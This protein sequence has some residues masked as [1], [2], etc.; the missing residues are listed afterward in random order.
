MNH[1]HKKEKIGYEPGTSSINNITS[2]LDV[3]RERCPDKV[4]LLSR[5]NGTVHRSISFGELAS[6]VER[7]S[8]GLYGRGLRAGD[9]AFL[10]I[11]MSV[12]LYVGMF[13]V[14]R[15]GAV[16]VFLDSWSRQDQLR[17]CL[18]HVQPTA[19]MA[20]ERAYA[21]FD[22]VPEAKNISLRI[23]CGSTDRKIGLLMD[24]LEGSQRPIEAV[25]QEDTALITFTTGSSGVPKGANRTHRFLAAQHRALTAHLPYGPED[26]DLPVFPIFSLNN[27]A[28]GVTTVLP[29]IDLAKPHETDGSALLS[30][31]IAT[32]ATTCTLSPSLLRGFTRAKGSETTSLKRVV[33]GGAPITREDVDRFQEAFPQTR[34]VILYG[35]TEVE[36]IAHLEASRMPESSAEEGVCV[37]TVSEALDVRLIRICRESIALEKGSIAPWEVGKSQVGE[38]VVSGEHVCRDYYRNPEAFARAKIRDGE[39]RVWHRTGDLCRFDDQHRLWFV[40]RVHNAIMRAGEVLFPVKP[41]VIM[42]KLTCVRTAA[43]LGLPHPSLGEEAVAVISVRQGTENAEALVREALVKAKVPVDRVIRVEEIP[44]DPRHHSK[45]DYQKLRDQLI[46]L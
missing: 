25:R 5:V 16:A 24:E 39:G 29:S 13:A 46:S 31:V 28:A 20:P 23:L 45:V 22:G 41:E 2:F 42:Q 9:R 43:Y 3:H 11:P 38:L 44:L 6:R 1:T 40:G 36:P 17:E 7:C 37:G 35:S 18:A 27:I 15:L 26:I 21:L 8:A 14:Q 10:F 19:L 4:A 32:S 34:L 30:Q 33:T 12:D